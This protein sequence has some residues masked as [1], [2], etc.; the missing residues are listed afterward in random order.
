MLTLALGIGATTAIF[1]VVNAVLIKPLPYPDSDE[2]VGLWHRAPGIDT[3]GLTM[4]PTMYFTYRDENR[5]FEHLGIWGA[6]GRSVTGVGDPEQARALGVT[7]GVL[8]AIGVQPTLGR[9]FTEAETT[10]QADGPDP[11]ILTYAYW[12]RKFGGDEAIIGRIMT[13]DGRA[14]EIVGVMPAGFR[15]IDVTPEVE[16]IS[17]LRFDRSQ[18]THGGF[19]FRGIA[20]LRPGVRLEEASADIERMLPIWLDAWPTAPGQMS[21]ETIAN[22]RLAPALQPLKADVIGSVATMLW[23]LLGT[24]GGVL[25]IACANIAN[26]TLVRCDA[27]R[28]EFAIRASLGARPGRIARELLVESLVL[29]AAGGGLGLLLAFVGLEALVA[30]GPSTLPRL[31]E[32]A[33]DTRALAFAIAASV[34]A[35]FLFGSIPAI[36]HAR[37]A[38]SAFGGGGRGMTATRERHATRHTLVVVQVA[39]ALVLVV[40]SGLMIRTFLALRDVDPG[41][42][43]P[44]QIQ[45]ARISITN[46]VTTEPERV[47]RI[48]RD[49]LDGIATVP[50]VVSAAFASAAPLEAGRVNSNF[51]YV[52]GRPYES[53]ETPPPVR[54]K[55]V[56][57]GYFRTMGTRLL[58]GRDVTW[59]DIDN[60]GHVALVSE[61]FARRE[62]GD[63]AAALGKRIRQNNTSENWHEVI[64][65]VQNVQEDALQQEPPVTVY[66][67]VRIAG[68]FGAPQFAFPAVAYV[69]RSERAG[70][71]SLLAEIR[72]AIWSV[73]ANLPVFLTRTMDSL[74][75]ESLAR[76]TFTLVILGLAG[77]MALA[78]GIVG[79]YGVIAY[80][81]SQRAREIGIRVALGAQ[82]AD[83]KRMFVRQ[84][85][86]LATI[87]AAAGLVAA[88]G[89]TRWIASLLYGIGPLDPPTYGIGFGLILAAAMLA[90]YLPARRAASIDPVETLKG[91]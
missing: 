23:T 87:G 56:S 29:G 22:Y 43:A 42:T 80:V 69:V 85:L 72:Q 38:G 2:L 10:P 75:A 82:A 16:L 33:V 24:I 55:F 6:G 54:F 44:E 73:N 76:T 15:F 51:A 77:A 9:M 45:V 1:S 84:G 25:L 3:E 32:V 31:H 67:P 65:I 8:E 27:R 47:T 91:E 36:K 74:Y 12:Q 17:P 48:Q 68:F 19:N 35:S 62:W 53:G 88:V 61:S 7:H 11:A 64:G 57:P 52:E 34:A 81:V 70:T 83:V 40:S 58:G 4:A 26:L 66:W 37:L 89:L 41:F 79:I 28:H 30:L 14:T 86:V 63:A 21:R 13:V 59:T 71:E 46:L 5:T 18:L 60:G 20:R 39:L 78:L 90:S 49:I 50:G